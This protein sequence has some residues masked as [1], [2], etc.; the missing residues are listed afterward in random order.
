MVLHQR[1]GNDSVRAG[2]VSSFGEFRQDILR[3]FIIVIDD[4]GRILD[5]P[6]AVRKLKQEYSS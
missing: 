6:L 4:R 2:L 5:V 3:E 1:E